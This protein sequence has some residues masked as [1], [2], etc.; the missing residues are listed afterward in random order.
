MTPARLMDERDEQRGR[1]PALRVV[2]GGVTPARREED[3]L[4]AAFL[5][6]DDDAF[7]DVSLGSGWA[8]D[9][10]SAGYAAE[11][12]ALQLNEN[13]IEL[14]IQPGPVPGAPADTGPAWAATARSRRSRAP[15]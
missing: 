10:L 15:G 11:V 1:T 3:A 12:G 6:G 13:I 4:V 9:Y 14:R 7:E 8:W 2:A 5:V